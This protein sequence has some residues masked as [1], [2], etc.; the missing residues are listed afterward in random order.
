MPGDV[1]PV[2]IF[3][4]KREYAVASAEPNLWMRRGVCGEPVSRESFVAAHARPLVRALVAGALCV[5]ATGCDGGQDDASPRADASAGMSMLPGTRGA[6]ASS[7]TAAAQRFDTAHAP[8]Q[9]A[10]APLLPPVMHTA[11]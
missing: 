11:D 6:T 3:E 2:R 4:M 5:I 1:V 10:S 9:N 7:A 8:T